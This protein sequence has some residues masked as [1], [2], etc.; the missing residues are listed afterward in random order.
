MLPGIPPSIYLASVSPRRH[1]LLNQIDVPHEV[2]LVPTPPGEDEPQHPGEAAHVYV[3]R[4]SM[5]K[6]VRANHFIE[7][8]RLAQ[9]PVLT[10]DTC[11]ILEGEVLGKPVD[12]ADTARILGLLSGKTHEVHTAIVVAWQG[13]YFTDVSIT[14]VSMKTLEPQEIK[15]YC[16]SQEG[17]GKAGAYGIQGLASV[18]IEHIAGSYSGVMGLPLFETCRLLRHAYSASA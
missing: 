5:D 14:R 12:D 13:Q 7:Q 15:A 17:N 3:Q 4:T 9:K 8:Q 2:L 1:E 18:F 10:A 6:A 16:A 11:V